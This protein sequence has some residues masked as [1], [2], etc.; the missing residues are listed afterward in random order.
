MLKYFVLF[1]ALTCLASDPKF[2][3]M[4]C[5]KISKGFY[6]G[7]KG[8]VVSF[9][10]SDGNYKYETQVEDCRGGSF[11]ESFREYELERCS[12]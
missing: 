10:I 12:K 9:Y 7:C 2:H 8:K 11:T 6:G 4:E 5:V 1:I 3:Y